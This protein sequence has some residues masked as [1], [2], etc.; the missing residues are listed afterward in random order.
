MTKNEAKRLE[1]D[2]Y[3]VSLVTTSPKH[4]VKLTK[5]KLYRF[6]DL[7]FHPNKF[8]T[9]L[10]QADD[11]ERIKSCNIKNFK[12]ITDKRAIEILFKNDEALL[13]KYRHK[14]HN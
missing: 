14:I 5:G 8:L 9:I 7:K 2:E 10:I 1:F 12:V 6:N 11:L 4:H 13:D 3:I